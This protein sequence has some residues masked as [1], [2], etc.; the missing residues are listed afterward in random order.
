MVPE[1]SRSADHLFP[2]NIRPPP[3]TTYGQ[4]LK[5]PELYSPGFTVIKYFISVSKKKASLIS[6]ATFYMDYYSNGNSQ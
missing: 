3:V 1:L 6:V 4:F 5:T 2:A